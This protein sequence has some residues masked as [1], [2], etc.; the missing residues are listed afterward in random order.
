MV[1]YWGRVSYVYVKMF[2]F[3]GCRMDCYRR[4]FLVVVVDVVIVVVY[5]G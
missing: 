3:G 2:F 5:F 4:G 1:V